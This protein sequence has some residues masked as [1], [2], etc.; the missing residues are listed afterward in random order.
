[1]VNPL[2][3]ISAKHVITHISTAEI[4]GDII[5]F[6]SL[7]S[8]MFLLMI[9][10]EPVKSNDI[11][12]SVKEF[13]KKQGNRKIKNMIKQTIED[14]LIGK[15]LDSMFFFELFNSNEWD[16]NYCYFFNFTIE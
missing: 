10:L 2:K 16:C 9:S 4:A 3:T 6:I 12:L 14:S 7:I 13:K 8:D 1:V 11:G 5:K 15:V